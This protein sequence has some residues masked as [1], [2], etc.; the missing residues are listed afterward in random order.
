MGNEQM[1]ADVQHRAAQIIHPHD[2]LGRRLQFPCNL[3][4]DVSG[5]HQIISFFRRRITREE[6]IDVHFAE[7]IFGLF[8]MQ[9]GGIFLDKGGERVSSFGQ[10]PVLSQFRRRLKFG[11]ANIWGGCR[12][13]FSALL[14]FH[15]DLF[16]KN[17]IVTKECGGAEDD[18]CQQ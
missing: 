9:A 8:Q 18:H 3:C 12:S 11:K 4:Q 10:F 14:L 7:Q 1:L 2:E 5:L 6:N 15:S 17:E 16:F 13:N